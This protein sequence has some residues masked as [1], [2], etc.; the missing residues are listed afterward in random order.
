MTLYMYNIHLQIVPDLGFLSDYNNRTGMKFFAKYNHGA[1]NTVKTL[2]YSSFFT[3]GPR[4]FN[5]LSLELR[6]P[7]TAN[8]PEERKKAKEKFKKRYDKWLVLVPDEPTTEE[9]NRTADSNSIVGQM[10]MHGR[11]VHRQWKIIWRRMAQEEQDDEE[12]P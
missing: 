12:A 4:L 5:L 3:Q 7:A 2:R 11:V 10:R 1:P 6:R 9:M 8:T